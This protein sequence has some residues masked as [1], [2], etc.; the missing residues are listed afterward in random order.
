[1][2]AKKYRAPIH[3][4]PKKSDTVFRGRFVVVKS[5]PNNLPHSRAGVLVS[6]GAARRA[7]DRNRIKRRALDSIDMG[8]RRGA[9]EDYLVIINSVPEDGGLVAEEISGALKN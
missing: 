8:G 1:M 3:R 6:R 5:S 4:F 9:G 2:L 7:V